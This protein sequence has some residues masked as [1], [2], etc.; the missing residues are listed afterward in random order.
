M[1]AALVLN[2]DASNAPKIADSILSIAAPAVN[3]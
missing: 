3:N 2:F 1:P